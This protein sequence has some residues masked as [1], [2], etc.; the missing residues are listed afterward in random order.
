MIRK[1]SWKSFD[2]FDYY[3]GSFKWTCTLYCSTQLQPQNLPKI[4]TLPKNVAI[5]Q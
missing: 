2:I 3:L 4:G 1:R 5:Y